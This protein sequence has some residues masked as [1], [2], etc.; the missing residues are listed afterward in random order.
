MINDR[1]RKAIVSFLPGTVYRKADANRKRFEQ[2]ILPSDV[3]FPATLL[4]P[5]IGLRRQTSDLR[6]AKKTFYVLSPF[7]SGAKVG[8]LNLADVPRHR[9]AA[10]RPRPYAA[11]VLHRR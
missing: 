4:I 7:P 2:S 10:A 9:D 6:N 1:A 3:F 5:D 11:N 8:D